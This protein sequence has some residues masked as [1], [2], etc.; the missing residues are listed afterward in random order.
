M[1][2]SRG[3]FWRWTRWVWG[4]VLMA[5]LC[6]CGEQ[7]LYSNL[8][9]QDANDMLAVLSGAGIK[10]QKTV[11]EDK[12][13]NI[14]T[15]K[16]DFAVATRVLREHGLPQAKFASMGDIFK[17]D[18]LMS[19]RNEERMRYIHAM[20]QELS[21]TLSLI[22]GVIAVRVQPVIP[23]SDPMTDRVVPSSAS[24]FIKHRAD[25]DLRPRTH[26]IKELVMASIEGLDYDKIAL[27]FFPAMPTE[28]PVPPPPKEEVFPTWMR[29]LVAGVLAVGMLACATI[30]LG[31]E[32]WDSLSRWQRGLRSRWGTR[33]RRA[34]SRKR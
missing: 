18:S 3:A 7:T 2:A 17:K 4:A 23:A 16:D 21:K 1:S 9:E 14:E 26:A 32:A 15:N 28:I 5:A 33:A 24:V 6:A 13:W 27:S 19:S 12:S 11:A 31:Q 22:D 34:D 10:A 25:M 8:S 29:A 20:S 30:L